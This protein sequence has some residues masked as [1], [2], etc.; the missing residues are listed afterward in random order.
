MVIATRKDGCMVLKA[1]NEVILVD[2]TGVSLDR[3]DWDSDLKSQRY[4]YYAAQQ[5]AQRH[6]SVTWAINP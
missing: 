3:F 6:W 2:S 5:Q 4:D 1:K